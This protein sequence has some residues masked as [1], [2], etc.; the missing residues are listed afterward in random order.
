MTLLW[1]S[2]LVILALLSLAQLTGAGRDFYKI[3]GVPRSA[4][5][6][7]IKW[8]GGHVLDIQVSYCSTD[9][10]VQASVPQACFAM[11]SRQESGQP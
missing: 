5:D 3:L 2:A 1:R 8:V 11:A 9:D 4:D 6:K 7:Q 10:S